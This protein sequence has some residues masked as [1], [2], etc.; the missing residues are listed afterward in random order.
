MELFIALDYNRAIILPTIAKQAALFNRELSELRQR[1][2][3]N[4][5]YLCLFPFE[6]AKRLN[7]ENFPDLYYAAISTAL[8]NNEQLSKN[9][10]VTDIQTITSKGIINTCLNRRI[11]IKF[12]LDQE[13]R[14]CLLELDIAYMNIMEDADEELT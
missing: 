8:E 5:P 13:T 12:T 7:Y 3:S 10:Y 11:K 2:G 1:Y 14:D 4:F 9:E 6:G